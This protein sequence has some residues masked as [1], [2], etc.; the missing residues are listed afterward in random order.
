MIS[1]SFSNFAEAVVGN[2]AERIRQASNV[3]QDAEDAFRFQGFAFSVIP[4]DVTRYRR[5]E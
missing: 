4:L 3:F 5:G 2:R 1:K